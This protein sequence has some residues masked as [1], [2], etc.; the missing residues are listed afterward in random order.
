MLSLLR[1]GVRFPHSRLDRSRLQ[2]TQLSFQRRR[3]SSTGLAGLTVDEFCARTSACRC[4]TLPSAAPEYLYV[5]FPRPRLRELALRGWSRNANSRSRGLGNRT[6]KYSGA[7]DGRVRH[8]Q[9]DV[10]AQN[11]STVR[12]ARPVDENLLRWNES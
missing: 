5:R 4:R 10:R 7:A 2:T 12:P 11:S 6:Y 8:R 3:F 9:A 1:A